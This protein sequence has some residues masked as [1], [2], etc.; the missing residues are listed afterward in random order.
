M[1]GFQCLCAHHITGTQCFDQPLVPHQG[2]AHYAWAEAV[3]LFSEC[4][5]CSHQNQCHPQ[6]VAHKIQGDQKE[7]AAARGVEEEGAAYS[8]IVHIHVLWHAFR[9]LPVAHLHVQSHICTTIKIA[10]NIHGLS[11]HIAAYTCEGNP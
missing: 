7:H 6:N 8:A 2:I 10:N 1:L 4:R 9:H 11:M 5:S 3:Y